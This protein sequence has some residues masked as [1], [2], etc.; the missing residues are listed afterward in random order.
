[1]RLDD[2]ETRSTVTLLE[3]QRRAYAAQEARLLAEQRHAD[4]LVF[5]GSWPTCAVIPRWTRS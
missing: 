4:R 1:M 3:G 2:L 5:P